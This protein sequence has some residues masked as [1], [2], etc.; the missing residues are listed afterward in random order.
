MKVARIRNPSG[1]T[2]VGVSVDLSP[3][4]SSCFAQRQRFSFPFNLKPMKVAHN[5]YNLKSIPRCAVPQPR[6]LRYSKFPS[7]LF[8][9]L[10][11]DKESWLYEQLSGME[12]RLNIPSSTP[13]L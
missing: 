3:P 10:N 8:K 9:V 6:R 4:G 5:V 7:V 2:I 11:R 1:R 13:I 12:A